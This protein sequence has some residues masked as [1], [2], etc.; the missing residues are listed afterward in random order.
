MQC[1]LFRGES[2]ERARRDGD[3]GEFDGEDEL[4]CLDLH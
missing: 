1:A 4:T 2:L 3:A